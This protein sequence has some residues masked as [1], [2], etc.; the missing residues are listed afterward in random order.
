MSFSLVSGCA[1]ASILVISPSVA[2][3]VRPALPSK[4]QG[5]TLFRGVIGP[6][7]PPGGDGVRLSPSW[8]TLRGAE[9]AFLIGKGS[10]IA[11][12]TSFR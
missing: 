9:A 3:T 10:D 1:A 4:T 12:L 5:P 6:S 8:P 11:W 7:V 2:L